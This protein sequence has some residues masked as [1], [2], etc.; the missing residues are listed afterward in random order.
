M[1][2]KTEI[3]HY[4]Y[5][6]PKDIEN[7]KLFRFHKLQII[8]QEFLRLSKLLSEIDLYNR[9]DELENDIDKKGLYIR[10]LS[11]EEKDYACAEIEEFLRTN[12]INDSYD[13]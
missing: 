9:L 2:K 13:L 1:S 8:Y 6:H 10:I 11:E 12:S 5:I 3:T 7:Q 4:T